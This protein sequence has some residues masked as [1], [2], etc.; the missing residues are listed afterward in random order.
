MIYHSSHSDD[1]LWYLI[2]RGKQKK[3][4]KHPNTKLCFKETKE[5]LETYS[6]EKHTFEQEGLG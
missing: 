1:S 4:L 6:E 3:K 2:L 5:L